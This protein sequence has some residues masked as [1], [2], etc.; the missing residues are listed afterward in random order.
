MNIPTYRHL[1]V[2]SAIRLALNEEEQPT[3]ELQAL[4]RII[5]ARSGYSQLTEQ[6]FS[7]ALQYLKARGEAVNTRYGYWRQA[8]LDELPDYHHEWE[9]G[10]GRV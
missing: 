10:T 1:K 8:E 5:L 4:T 2:T 9:I 7:R 3:G 6:D